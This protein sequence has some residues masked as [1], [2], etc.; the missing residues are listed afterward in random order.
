MDPF[1]RVVAA[2][3]DAGVRYLVIGVW[4]PNYYAKGTLFVTSD[5]D[6]FM[7]RDA[8]NLLRAWQACEAPGLDRRAVPPRR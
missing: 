6:L 4:G 5:Q 3:N 7:P 8:S 1:L 2:L